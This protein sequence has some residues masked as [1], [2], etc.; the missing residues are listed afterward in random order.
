MN[1][2]TLKSHDEHLYGDVSRWTYT[3]DLFPHGDDD[4]ISVVIGDTHATILAWSIHPEWGGGCIWD[5]FIDNPRHNE[6]D[7]YNAIA[8]AFG[9]IIN[10]G[11]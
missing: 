11:W 8:M 1:H 10:H 5:T 2:L 3:S 9:M 4:T 7:V 6:D